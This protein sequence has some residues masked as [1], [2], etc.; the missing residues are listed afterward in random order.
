MKVLRDFAAVVDSQTLI[1]SL[2]AVG[3]TYLC[4]R[5]DV[6]ADIPTGL[7]GLAGFIRRNNA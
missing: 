7:I 2:L 6:K 4:E 3:S 1:V 5:F